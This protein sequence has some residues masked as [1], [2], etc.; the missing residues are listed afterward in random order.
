M[1]FYLSAIIRCAHDFY[2]QYNNVLYK[3]L[4]EKIGDQVRIWIVKNISHLTHNKDPLQSIHN[5]Y[6]GFM[7]RSCKYYCRRVPKPTS[8]I[9]EPWL[10]WCHN[11]SRSCLAWN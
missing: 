5:A 8:K 3:A 11:P 10:L 9:A 1:E 4:C 6:R 2:D 7:V